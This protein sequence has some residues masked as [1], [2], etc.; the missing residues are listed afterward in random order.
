MGRTKMR[1]KREPAVRVT[2]Q[3]KLQARKMKGMTRAVTG[4]TMA[5]RK[6]RVQVPGS[7][8]IAAVRETIVNKS[9]VCEP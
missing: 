6:T 8:T 5:S 2:R 7:D 3:K 1:L 9:D 4:G